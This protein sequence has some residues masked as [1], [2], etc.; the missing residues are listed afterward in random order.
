MT[1]DAARNSSFGRQELSGT[2][3]R[4]ITRLC[5]VGIC[6]TSQ[7]DA[8]YLMNELP[9]DAHR[10]DCAP[11]R[12]LKALREAGSE[13]KLSRQLGVN[14]LYISQYFREGIEPTDQTENGR[15]VRVKMFLPKRKRKPRVIK[16]KPEQLTPEWFDG[17]RASAV[18]AM[19]KETR[20]A[21]KVTR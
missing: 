2:D 5:T 3:K 14:I 13:R 18:K 21:L 4:F 17:L 20:K 16:P 9:P 6:P 15:A 8:V 1:S 10:N 12:L 7:N 19:A 11:R